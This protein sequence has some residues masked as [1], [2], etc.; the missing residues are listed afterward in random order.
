M[1]SDVFG[2]VTRPREVKLYWSAAHT[3]AMKLSQ[4]G[5]SQSGKKLYI[6]TYSLPD[7]DYA[8]EL[9]KHRP[10]G[11]DVFMMAHSKFQDKAAIL[12]QHFVEIQIR[13]H[14][15]M[16]SKF[17][18]IEPDTVFLGSA[19]F[20]RS[21]WHETMIGIKCKTTAAGL[22]Q[23]TW[24]PAWKDKKAIPMIGRHCEN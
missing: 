20:G 1:K 7:L 17:A 23:N 18:I 3:W 4:I 13:L 9:L 19:N 5:K 22:Y 8:I 12:I 6:A 16:H 15:E 10:T 11:K 21:N 14:P 2:V 24:L